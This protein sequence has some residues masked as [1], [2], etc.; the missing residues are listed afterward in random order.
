MIPHYV[1]LSV[2]PSCHSAGWATWL[3]DILVSSGVADSTTGDW[4]RDA[5]EVSSKVLTNLNGTGQNFNHI[6]LAYELPCNYG[7]PADGKG[8]IVKLAHSCGMLVSR[9]WAFTRYHFLTRKVLAIPVRDWKGN[10]PKR[11]MCGRIADQIQAMG[12]KP[13]TNKTHELDAIGVGFHAQ[14]LLAQERQERQTP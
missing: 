14:K 11:I 4:L 1:L 13:R 6:V 9:F 7:S 3:D 10:A 12:Y 5:Q 2:D 8:D